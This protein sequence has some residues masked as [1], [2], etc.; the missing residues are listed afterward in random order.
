[1]KKE[2]NAFYFKKIGDTEEQMDNLQKKAMGKAI[3]ASILSLLIVAEPIGVTLANSAIFSTPITVY[4]IIG[5]YFASAA[6]LGSTMVGAVM[7]AKDYLSEKAELGDTLK[8]LNDKVW[9]AKNSASQE[10]ISKGGKSK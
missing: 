1:M 4:D 6:I 5:A 7:D 9:N 2:S 3:A 8:S 10:S